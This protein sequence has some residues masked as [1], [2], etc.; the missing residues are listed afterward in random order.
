[1]KRPR[2]DDDVDL[3][4]PRAKYSIEKRPVRCHDRS[5]AMAKVMLRALE[6][7]PG[8]GLFVIDSVW[9]AD[10]VAFWMRVVAPSTTHLVHRQ[11]EV[12]APTTD[13]IVVRVA[14]VEMQ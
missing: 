3:C 11:V 6:V 1:M 9:H 13:Q 2:L 4:G 12:Y 5:C 14:P 10:D 7:T 8:G